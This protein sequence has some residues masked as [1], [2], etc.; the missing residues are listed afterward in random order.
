MLMEKSV[1]SYPLGPDE[2]AIRKPVARPDIATSPC[3]PQ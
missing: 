3:F 2:P 1:G